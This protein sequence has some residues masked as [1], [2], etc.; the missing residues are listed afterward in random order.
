M[1]AMEELSPFQGALVARRDRYNAQFRLARTLDAQGFLAH[2]RDAVGPV[3]DASGGEPVPV[4]D[5]LVELSVALASRRQPDGFWPLLRSLSRFVGMEP[6]R[7][8]VS[9]ANAL[10]HLGAS[11][12]GRPASWIDTVVTLAG[13]LDDVAELLEAGAVAAWRCGLAQLRGPAVESAGKLRPEVL[14][15]ALGVESTVDFERLAGD[16]WFDPGSASSP[17][18]LR[19]V[20]R[21]GEFRGFGGVFARP[22]LVST[23]DG[24]WYAVDGEDVWQVFADRFS[25]GYRRVA[26]LPDPDGGSD[27]MT[28]AAGRVTDEATGQV[29]DVPELAEASSWASSN[30]TLA[31]TT[32]WTHGIVFVARAADP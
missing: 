29:L 21:V 16:P 31:A 11:P 6:R 10:H 5:A 18:A 9:L 23:S 2:L 22:P 7:V 12:T 15:V 19:V 28:L 25:V 3:V 4:T 27:G 8:P 20:R 24:R 32:P 13:Q 1:A 30:G 26:S 17:V 14:R